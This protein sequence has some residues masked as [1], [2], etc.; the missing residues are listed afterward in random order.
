MEQA[1]TS[2]EAS[3]AGLLARLPADMDLDGLAREHKA[4]ERGREIA[5]GATL[6]RLSLARGPGGKSLRETAAWASTLGIAEISNPGVKYRLDKAGEFLAAVMEALLAAR[7][8][9]GSLFWPGRCLRLAD[10]TCISKR[11]SAGTDWR[12]H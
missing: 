9:S 10:G 1:S 3:F 11:G 12:V 4:I 6:L 7:A 2:P 5:D 8:A